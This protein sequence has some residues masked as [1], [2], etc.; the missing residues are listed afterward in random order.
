MPPCR[1][2]LFTGSSLIV[3]FSVSRS[4]ISYEGTLTLMKHSRVRLA[5]PDTERG[6]STGGEKAVHLPPDSGHQIQWDGASHKAVL[7]RSPPPAHGH[8]SPDS[9]C[10]AFSPEA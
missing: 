8:T 4:G 1:A 6:Y 2:T 3:R 9:P 10:L 5:R 7:Q